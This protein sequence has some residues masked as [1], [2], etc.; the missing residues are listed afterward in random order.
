VKPILETNTKF[1]NLKGVDDEAKAKLE[2][3]VNFLRNPK[4]VLLF[5]SC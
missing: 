4:V 3:I 5:Q 1:S 2:E